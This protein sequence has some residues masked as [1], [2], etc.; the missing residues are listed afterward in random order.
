MKETLRQVW[1]SQGLTLTQTA[2]TANISDTTLAKLN[3]GEL[4]SN[5]TKLRVCS[6]LGI[7]MDYLQTHIKP[8]ERSTE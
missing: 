4:V 6:A 8:E 5:V 7:S 2:R 1:E 3:R